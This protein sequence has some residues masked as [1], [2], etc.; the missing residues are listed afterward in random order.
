MFSEIKVLHILM[1]TYDSGMSRMVCKMSCITLYHL[2]QN[3]GPG[4]RTG[5][6]NTGY[7][8]INKVRQSSY[9]PGVA[10]RVPGS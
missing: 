10:Q 6:R 7:H 4:L 8:S 3:L 2:E 5:K 1:L 9:R